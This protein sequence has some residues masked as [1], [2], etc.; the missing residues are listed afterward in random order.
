[1]WAFLPS[2][3][4]VFAGWGGRIEVTSGKLSLPLGPVVEPGNGA[5][6][7]RAEEPGRWA[8]GLM[9]TEV[10]CTAFSSAS[11]IAFVKR[12]I[13]ERRLLAARS[14]WDP[15]CWHHAV[16]WPSR[17]G[18]SRLRLILKVATAAGVFSSHTSLSSAKAT[19]WIKT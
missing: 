11:D 19:V 12:Q 10:V 15:H 3:A 4:H 9:E 17:R 1:M 16:A 7:Q 6:Y 14:D 18:V 13:E 2:F 8:S 5:V